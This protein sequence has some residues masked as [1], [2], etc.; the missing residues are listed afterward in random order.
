MA[1]VAEAISTAST[2]HPANFEK[3]EWEGWMKWDGPFDALSANSSQNSPPPLQFVSGSLG[4]T[5]PSELESLPPVNFSPVYAL[6]T[7]ESKK[8]KSSAIASSGNQATTASGRQPRGKKISHN[9]IEKRYRSNLNDKI[10]KLRDSVPELRSAQ[11]TIKRRPQKSIA[12]DSE[13]SGD[14]GASQGLKF[15]KAT[16]LVK[17]TEYIQQ[18]ERQNQRLLAEVSSL[19][20]RNS[21]KS[22]LQTPPVISTGASSTPFIKP[23]VPKSSTSGS[24]YEQASRDDLK[25]EADAGP[26]GMI[27]IPEDIR[28]LREE[29]TPQAHYAPETSSSGAATTPTVTPWSEVRGMIPLSESWQRFRGQPRSE[30]HYAPASTNARASTGEE[31]TLNDDDE[32]S[33]LSRSRMVSRLLVGS[34]AGLMVMEGFSEGEENSKIE[35][36]GLFSLPSEL[37]TE[38]RGFRVPIR[39]RII[40]FAASGRAEK[41]LPILILSFFFLLICLTMFVYFIPAQSRAVRDESSEKSECRQALE[42]DS[43]ES[44]PAE[45]AYGDLSLSSPANLGADESTSIVDLYAWRFINWLGLSKLVTESHDEEA[46]DGDQTILGRERW[47]AHLRVMPGIGDNMQGG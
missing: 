12:S 41:A 22:Q 27:Q 37:L 20:N 36:R 31:A 9:V 17:A 15:N 2:T 8:R 3:E 35:R 5:S 32:S 33:G 14:D 26:A 11:S 44:L 4:S 25:R 29:A 16:V 45:S 6:P 1:E 40:A 28:R 21:S 10:A 43:P 47:L 18:L 46:A 24:L 42:S 13:G 39:N 19:R 34:L 30:E 23:V 38:S 7:T